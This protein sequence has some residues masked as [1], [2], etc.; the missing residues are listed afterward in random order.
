MSCLTSYC[1]LHWLLRSRQ[2][3]SEEMHC[4]TGKLSCLWSWPYYNPLVSESWQS[5][6]LQSAEITGII[7]ARDKPQGIKKDWNGAM[8]GDGCDPVVVPCQW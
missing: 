2:W 7:G 3:R 8:H 6:S 4:R 5:T 1:R